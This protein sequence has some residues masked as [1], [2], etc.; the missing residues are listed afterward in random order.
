M[1]LQM[2]HSIIGNELNANMNVPFKPDI[3]SAFMEL[4]RVNYWY[5]VD[6]TLKLF[7][8]TDGDDLATYEAKQQQLRLMRSI[9]ENAIRTSVAKYMPVETTLWKIKYTGK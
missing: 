7:F 5:P 3:I 8:N 1:I 4:S 2:I 6:D 9:L